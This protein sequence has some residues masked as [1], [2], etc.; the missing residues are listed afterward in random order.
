M[1]FKKAVKSY[2]R[3]SRGMLAGIL[4]SL[5]VFAVIFFLYGLP[6]EPFVYGSVL[7]LTFLLAGMGMGLVREYRRDWELAQIRELVLQMPVEFPKAVGVDE[8]LYQEMIR[9]LGSHAGQLKQKYDRNQADLMDYYTLWAHQIKTPIAAMRLLLQSQDASDSMLE[10]ELFKIEQYVEMVLGYLRCE[11]MNA[12]LS[13]KEHSLDDLIRQA[14][15]K[16]KKMFILR[17]I[18]L[19][20]EP[21]NTQ[22]LT[23][24][25]WLVFVLEQILSNALK[26][27]PKGEIS[28][29][30]DEEQEQTLVIED[31][32][33]GIAPEDIPR[34]FERG[35]TGENGRR[36]KRSTGIGLYLS[37]QIMKKLSHHIW[38]ESKPG[39]GTRVY[40][41]LRRRDLEVIS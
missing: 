3:K 8:E 6:M 30:M 24:E 32:G 36:D 5:C 29:Y 31:T 7:V 39:E 20:Y 34:V 15:K 11:S 19:R 4:G 13:F 38:I 18:S 22:V 33:I 40:L 21:V 17:K 14:V 9:A 16:Y 10:M 35:F 23:D 26:Y 28:I 2:I 12:D 37:R 41:C 1:D 27:T 25:K